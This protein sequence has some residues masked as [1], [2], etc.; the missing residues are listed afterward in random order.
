MA[1]APSGAIRT[2]VLGK[3]PA[4]PQ[5]YTRAMASVPRP[6]P[7]FNAPSALEYFDALVADDEQFPLLEAAIAIA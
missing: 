5:V 3:E 4:T 1:P 7:T 6:T 2:R